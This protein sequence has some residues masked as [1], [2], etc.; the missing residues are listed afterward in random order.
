MLRPNIISTSIIGFCGSAQDSDWADC[1]D[2]LP[3]QQHHGESGPAGVHHSALT[4]SSV[5]FLA[6]PSS[7]IVLSR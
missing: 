2:R 5:I 6:S 1:H 4:I 3:E 7:I